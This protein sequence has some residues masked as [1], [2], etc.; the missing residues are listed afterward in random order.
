M[1]TQS[2]NDQ[3]PLSMHRV[4]IITGA[5]SGIGA[6]SAIE[7]A[8]PGTVSYL[9]GRRKDRLEAVASEI[10]SSGGLAEVCPADVR[11]S[12]SLS[13]I[14]QNAH[15]QHGRI[16][17]LIACAAMHDTASVTTGDPDR[18][19]ELIDTNVLGTLYACR[20]VLPYMEEAGAGDVVIVSSVSGRV[21]YPGE[22]VYLSSKHATVALGDSLRQAVAGKGIRVTVIEPGMVD[23]AML[24]NPFARELRK[25]IRPLDPDDC[26]RA[27]RFAIEQ[28]RHCSVNEIV[29][30]PTGQVL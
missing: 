28:P 30:R 19:H 2:R 14:A 4:G 11:D 20:A 9:I 27:I 24:D 6:A 25:T 29:L 23:T 8:G 10:L 16:D 26:A 17:L 15:E 22:P 3:E 7:L 5:G 21:T 1:G 13:E 12:S 18:W